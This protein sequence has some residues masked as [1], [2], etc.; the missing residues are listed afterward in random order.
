MSTSE[1]PHGEPV[2]TVL[3]WEVRPGRERQF[4]EWTHGITRCARRF[5]GNEGVSWLRPGQGHRYHVLLRWSDPHR[6][7]AWLESPERAS[8]HARIAG[9]ATEIGSERQSTTG[10]ETWFSLPGITVQAPPR[11]KMVLTTFLGAYPFTFLIQWLVLPRT[12]DWPLPLRAAVLPL[13]LLPILTYLVMP[14]LSRLLRLWLYRPP[15][16]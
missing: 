13:V 14:R 12:A 11:W 1:A 4:E 16:G 9:V 7:A 15:E 6:L 5:P 8:W 2:T 10:M 3:T